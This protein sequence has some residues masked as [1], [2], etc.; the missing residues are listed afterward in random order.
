MGLKL[1]Q[2]LATFST[3]VLQN[4]LEYSPQAGELARK[5]EYECCPQPE[6]G[7]AN[8]DACH[9]LASADVNPKASPCYVVLFHFF[10]LV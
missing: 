7:N 4:F 2:D 5:H 10:C 1:G 9:L 3:P 8:L 6:G